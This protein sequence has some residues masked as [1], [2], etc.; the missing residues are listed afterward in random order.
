MSNNNKNR[1]NKNPL[2]DKSKSDRAP[3]YDL[4]QSFKKVRQYSRQ[5]KRQNTTQGTTCSDT[6]RKSQG[7][8]GVISNNSIQYDN[9]TTGIDDRNRYDRLEDRFL[10]F[11]DKNEKQHTDLRIELEG[12]IDK[13]S[14]GIKKDLIELGKRI[15]KKLSKQ[16]YIWTVIGIV[17][18]V[19]LIWN[20]SYQEVAKTPSKLVDME[21][22]VEK[23]EN[24]LIKSQPTDSIIST[25]NE[26][27]K[28]VK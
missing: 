17:A 11:S 6:R 13:S 20:L 21:N 5:T 7:E 9:N 4:T 28:V 25:N 19:G 24:E 8:S 23:V 16:W 10:S 27:N 26:S 2:I 22:R 1:S 15:D 18:M 3:E 12:K 14:E